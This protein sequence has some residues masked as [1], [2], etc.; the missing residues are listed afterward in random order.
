MPKQPIFRVD[1]P[2]ELLA[3][4][5]LVAEAKFQVDPDD[6]DLWGSPY[7]HALA[8][9]ISDALLSHYEAHEDLQAATAHRQWLMSLRTNVVLP[10]V[11]AQ[12]KKNTNDP[13]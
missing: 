13:S 3:L 10:V 9:R 2:V 8:Q 5:R 12:L 4:W 7:V 1:D 6:Q 11:E